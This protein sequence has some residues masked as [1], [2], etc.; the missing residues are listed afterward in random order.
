MHGGSAST[1]PSCP[2]PTC[3][4]ADEHAPNCF[5][6][7]LARSPR[8]ESRSCRSGPSRT[9]RPVL[10][11]APGVA[12]NVREI[13]L[14]GGTHGAGQHRRSPSSTSGSTPR[15]PTMVIRGRRPG[16]DLGLDA[17]HQA[18]ATPEIRERIARR[19]AGSA[20]LRRADGVLRGE[21]RDVRPPRPAGAR[22]VRRRAHDRS[23]AR[24][25]RPQPRRDR[26]AGR[27]HT[28]RDR[29]AT[30]MASRAASRTHRSPPRSTSRASGMPLWPR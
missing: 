22:S 1:A 3:R 23:L 7:I 25:L 19:A 8:A 10:R 12:A 15:P 17:T 16:H 2:S 24:A 20:D 27:A 26:T 28:R 13:V 6:A 18:L 4:V 5:A 11:D 21:L 14:M 29:R 9:S 30:C